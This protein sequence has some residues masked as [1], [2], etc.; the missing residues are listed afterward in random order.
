M[1]VRLAM[2]KIYRDETRLST[3]L[4]L[5]IRYMVVCELHVLD[6]IVG[7]GDLRHSFNSLPF[8]RHKEHI[9]Q[10]KFVLKKRLFFFS[11]FFEVY[12]Y[13]EMR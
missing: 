8:L 6:V 7:V 1:I 13:S 10:F 12:C 2:W 4:V 3:C 9:I 11:F 5:Q